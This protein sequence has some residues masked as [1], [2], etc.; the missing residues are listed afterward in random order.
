M[1]KTLFTAGFAKPTKMPRKSPTIPGQAKSVRELYEKFVSTGVPPEGMQGEYYESDVD[2]YPF[3]VD[4]EDYGALNQHAQNLAEQSP[5]VSATTEEV[6][7]SEENVQPMSPDVS[8][9]E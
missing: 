3:G 6:R 4:L 9:S 7:T 8:E 2:A 1:F 5:N